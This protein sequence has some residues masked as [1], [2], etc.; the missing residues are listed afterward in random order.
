MK[1]DSSL[2]QKKNPKWVTKGQRNKLCFKY[3]TNCKKHIEKRKGW[4]T[5]KSNKQNLHLQQ[6]CT[7]K[8]KQLKLLESY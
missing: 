8:Y 4:K 3:P 7:L 5:W 1:K 2:N 6:R